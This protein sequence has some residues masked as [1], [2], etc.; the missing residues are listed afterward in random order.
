MNK[1]ES[2]KNVYGINE[3]QGH[4]NSSNMTERSDDELSTIILEQSISNYDKEERCTKILDGKLNSDVVEYYDMDNYDNEYNY[5][6]SKLRL[7]LPEDTYEIE[8]LNGDII[9]HSKGNN[10]SF[11]LC[12]NGVNCSKD[13]LLIRLKDNSYRLVK[14][15]YKYTGDV[16]PFLVWLQDIIGFAYSD[17]LIDSEKNIYFFNIEPNGYSRRRYFIN[18][19]DT[20]K[21][22]SGYNN[23]IVE[24]SWSKSDSLKIP[25]IVRSNI[26][27]IDDLGFDDLD[28]I[29]SI[30]E[31]TGLYECL[32]I[33]KKELHVKNLISNIEYKFNN[34]DH[35]EYI[36][37]NYEDGTAEILPKSIRFEEDN[38]KAVAMW[39]Y[40]TADIK[41]KDFEFMSD[42]SPNFILFKFKYDESP[43]RSII[44]H[45][46]TTIVKNLDKEFYTFI[47]A[48]GKICS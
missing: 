36:L 48:S 11:L 47:D 16:Q 39:L 26:V 20:I 40:K 38:Y 35:K 22:Y 18:V 12:D 15:V 32:I 25:L 42:F 28:F 6:L 45:K 34:N 23:L 41:I 8:Y 43:Y 5:F 14:K 2:F 29:A 31:K 7:K 19:G 21:K 13:Y 17:I 46:H 10:K 1:E 44:I 24:R 9:F 27:K 4:I 30:L 33:N 3:H 37:V